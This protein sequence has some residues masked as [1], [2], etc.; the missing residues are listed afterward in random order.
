MAPAAEPEPPCLPTSPPVSYLDKIRACNRHDPDRFIP[1][2]VAGLR[3]G[4]LLRPFATELAR[5]PR[6]FEA[7]R[8]GVAMCDTLAD[9]ETRSVALDEVTARLVDDGVIA[10]VHGERFPVTATTMEAALLTVDRTAAVHFGVRAFGQHLNGFVR[11]SGGLWMWIARRARDRT[12]APG[13]LDQ[14]AAG[15]LPFGIGRQANLVK[16]CREEASI[17][18]SLA[19][20]ARPV[21][22][23]SYCAQTA[24]GL[25][26]DLLH[27]YDLELDASFTPRARDGEVEGFELW[28]IDAVADAVRDGD[29][30]KA[31]CNLV[32]ID[33]LV[34][35]GQ[36]RSGGPD[37]A[38][39]V[40]E[41]R[42]PT[43][44]AGPPQ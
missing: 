28:P 32:I 16:E 1:F 26:P 23:V 27:C 44:L 11:R 29:D 15:G 21:G 35:H 12:L 33:F 4:W 13:K 43:D 18:A 24:A 3:V 2:R 31:N 14:L 8:H 17:P 9:F 10:G 19:R 20:R 30:F 25:K 40:R 37:Y 36:L 38:E 42:S 39:I 7:S 5:W 6:V 41:L 22:Q 34:R